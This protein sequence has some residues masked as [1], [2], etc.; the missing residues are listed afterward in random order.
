[1][2]KWSFIAQILEQYFLYGYK[3]KYLEGILT[4]C[5]ISKTQE[6]GYPLEFSVFQ[7]IKFWPVQQFWEW[8]FCCE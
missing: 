4:L 8:T 5:L 6:L 3:H 7:A 2:L 1:M